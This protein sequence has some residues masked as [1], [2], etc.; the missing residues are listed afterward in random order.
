MKRYQL[1]L[2]VGF[3]RSPLVG[4]AGALARNV[5]NSQVLKA[6][7]P[8]KGCGGARGP[9]KKVRVTFGLK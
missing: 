8:S 5:A 1:D 7:R 4:T 6:V 3:S 2:D 9:I